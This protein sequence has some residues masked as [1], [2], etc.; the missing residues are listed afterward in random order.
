[1]TEELAEF[2]TDTNHAALVPGSH[3]WWDD[4]YAVV[5]PWEFEL[6]DISVPVLLQHGSQ[7]KFIPFGHGQWLATHI[8]GV[9][10]RLLD[11]DGHLT[12]QVHRIS[13]VHCWLRQHL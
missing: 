1:L 13:D 12:L 3:G 7:D 4:I 11:D 9:T 6:A 8:P 10:A 5:H 2:I